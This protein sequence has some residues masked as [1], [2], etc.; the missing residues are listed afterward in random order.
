MKMASNGRSIVGTLRWLFFLIIILGAVAA[1]F[2]FNLDEYVKF[3]Y[4]KMTYK[5]TSDQ[6]AKNFSE[7][8]SKS[9]GNI[10]VAIDIRAFT[11]YAFLEGMGVYDLE[12]G[13]AKSKE[14]QQLEKDISTRLAA[15]STNR[16]ARWKQFYND[17][18]YNVYTYLYYVLTLGKPPK[19][20]YIVPKADIAERDVFMLGGFNKILQDFFVTMKLDELY[21]WHKN[22]GFFA[23][24]DAYDLTTLAAQQKFAHNYLRID[25]SK[26]SQ[27]ILKVIPLPYESHYV[28]YSIWYGHDV[29]IIDG[30]DA[31][32][33]PLNWHEYL[34]VFV[35]PAVKNAVW[36]YK[37]K[38]N[39]IFEKNKNMPNIIGSYERLDSFVAECLIMPLEHRILCKTSLHKPKRMRS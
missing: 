25:T 15:V 14:R 18:P 13:F 38:F 31:S 23:A 6:T 4:Y 1:F 8:Y 35:S 11:L 24:A 34:H 20:E 32:E 16:I 28:A 3:E 27:V 5:V 30:P 19:F 12:L 26:A 36:A 39:D 37:S 10:C 2:S 9:S 33:G 21:A 7:C 17:H 22:A 29:Y